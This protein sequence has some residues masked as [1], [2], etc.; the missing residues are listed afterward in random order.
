MVGR[1]AELDRLVR[2]VPTDPKAT[3]AVALI[4]GE[5]GVG[6]TRLV[7][8][9]V[10][11]LAGQVPVL[12]GQADPGGL[13]RAFG[14]LLDAL[15]DAPAE[16]GDRSRPLDERIDA[17]IAAV[18][19]ATAGAPAVL[20]FEDLHWADSESLTLF[21]RL[22]EPD[23]GPLALVGTYR[24]DA[25]HRRHPVSELLPRLERRHAVTHVALRRLTPA[26]VGAFLAAV[27]GSTPSYR[28]VEALSLIYI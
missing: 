26:E 2:L 7:A 10:D 14:L 8:E 11:R 24:P 17:G 25:V 15:P 20:L 3:P 22:A 27:H 18:R 5:A 6:K 13:S 4:A 1:A 28:V 19:D 9:L 16:I 23:C 21:E 12:A